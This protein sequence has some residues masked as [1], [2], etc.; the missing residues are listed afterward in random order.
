VNDSRDDPLDEPVEVFGAV[1]GWPTRKGRHH[2]PIDE[3]QGCDRLVFNQC[4]IRRAVV[5]MPSGNNVTCER[6]EALRTLVEGCSQEI[7]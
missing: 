5:K 7:L 4:R 3:R 6:V 2:Y 1:D